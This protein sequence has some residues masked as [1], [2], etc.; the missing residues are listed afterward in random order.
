MDLR[1]APAVPIVVG[2]LAGLATSRSGLAL[3]G[4]L[5]VLLLLS[6]V[7]LGGGAGRG[8]LWFGFGC[9]VGVLDAGNPAELERGRPVRAVGT[10]TGAWRHGPYGSQARFTTERL[11]QRRTVH[12]LRTQWHLALPAGAETPEVGSR[13]AVRGVLEVPKPT[14]NGLPGRRPIP[15]IR[16]KS[17][18]LVGLIAPPRGTAALS[19]RLRSELEL[20]VFDTPGGRGPGGAWARALL[21]GDTGALD[22]R[23]VVALRGLGLGHLVAVSGLH[24]GILAWWLGAV[25]PARPVWLR[26]LVIALAA[27]F[28]ALLVGP[29]ASVLRAAWMTWAAM[30]GRLLSRPPNP[31]NALALAAGTLAVARPAWVHD[32]G[33]L[34]TLAATGGIVT[35]GPS[36]ESSFSRFMP[37]CLAQPLSISCAAQVGVLPW[38]LAVFGH[39]TPLA[40]LLNLVAVPWAAA[41]L[42]LAAV[43]VGS[44]LVIPGAGGLAGALL[45]GMARPLATVAELAPEMRFSL[46]VAVPF[47]VAAAIA[48]VVAACCLKPR[49]GRWGALLLPALLWTPTAPRP[50][51]SLSVL[52]VGQ[53]D[54]ILVRDGRRALLVDGGGWALGDVAGSVLVPTLAAAGLRKLDAVVLTHP[55]RDH[56]RGLVQLLDRLPVAEVWMASG[57]PAR[58]CAGELFLRRS[59]RRRVV[60]R[61]ASERLGRWRFRMLAPGPTGPA[62]G[63]SND[64]SLVILA[65][66]EGERFLLTGDLEAAGERSLVA[67]EGEELTAGVL[68]LA[69][70]GSKSSSSDRLLAAVAPRVAVASA[71]AGNPYGHPSQVVLERLARAGVPLLR[72]DLQGRITFVWSR[73]REWI[74]D[75]VGKPVAYH[76]GARP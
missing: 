47:A 14:A 64:G 11:S 50:E 45:D 60:W 27:G 70:H 59:V 16:V 66:A 68:K 29:R 15:R 74:V 33:F 31:A 34:L 44:E 42:V 2:V 6:A 52:D 63:R 5:L 19:S 40:P 20:R 75:W 3:D 7:A 13:L 46:P 1:T 48:A 32:L 72:T 58:S 55:D 54:A 41:S 25:A 8:L 30:G 51:L 38:S 26:P 43:W 65:E 67:R 18:R 71:G 35:L 24:L 22:E 37:A 36:L 56:C 61:G 69:H 62:S 9:L 4:R 23:A 21:L 76:A 73:E 57:W 12:L 28:Y 53:G 39:W 10:V 49:R 17:E